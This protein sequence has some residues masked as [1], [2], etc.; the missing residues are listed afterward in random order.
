MEFMP[1][2]TWIHISDILRALQD[3][4]TLAIL[5]WMLWVTRQIMDIREAVS[6]I[7]G[8]LE[9]IRNNRRVTLDG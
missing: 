7:R 1:F 8:E 3:L 9:V 5:I 4:F 6:S 2:D